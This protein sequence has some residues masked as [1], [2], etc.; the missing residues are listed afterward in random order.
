MIFKSL[1]APVVFSIDNIPDL[2]VGTVQFHV[3][4]LSRS[5]RA[6]VIT[7]RLFAVIKQKYRILF[8]DSK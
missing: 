7:C 3:C 1:N 8:V 4:Q 6:S 5:H 2:G